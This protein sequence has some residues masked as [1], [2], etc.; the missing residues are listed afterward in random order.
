MASTAFKSS[1]VKGVTAKPYV[2]TPQYRAQPQQ[3]HHI[4]HSLVQSDPHCSD[5]N[6]TG[7]CGDGVTPN[8]GMG[9]TYM[10]T[11]K[12]LKLLFSNDNWWH[13]SY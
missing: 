10:V 11:Q 5:V 3:Q 6:S 8:T 12:W 1:P 7:T 9:V 2:N 4:K 13:Y